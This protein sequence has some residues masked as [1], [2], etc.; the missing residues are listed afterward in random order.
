MIKI[1]NLIKF[2]FAKWIFLPPPKKKIIIYDTPSAKIIKNLLTDRYKTNIMIYHRRFEE[3]NI[4]IILLTFLN[5]NFKK[6]I[7][8]N[9]EFNYIKYVNPKLIITFVDNL[10]DFYELKKDFKSINFIS[11]QNGNRNRAFFVNSELADFKRV[12]LKNFKVDFFFVFNKAYKKAFKKYIDGNIVVSGSVKNNEVSFNNNLKNSKTE[13]N[14]LYISTF[15]EFRYN[16]LNVKNYYK[17][18]HKRYSYKDFLKAE[19]V[20]IPKIV[21]FCVSKKAKLTILAKT[22]SKKEHLF[23]KNIIKDPNLNWEFFPKPYIESGGLY[24]H[25][26]RMI[27]SS[28]AVIFI[29]SFLGYEAL[30]RNTPCAVF[31]IRKNFLDNLKCFNFGYPA[32]LQED[33]PFWTNVCSDKKVFKVLNAVFK[34]NKK[35]W[36]YLKKKYLSEVIYYNSKNTIIKKKI[37]E[38]LC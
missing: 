18:G 38:I 8:K 27:D 32:N 33:G 15:N 31:S 36:N 30:C 1:R 6:S 3:F 14:I 29:D 5:F 13:K 19:L 21:K 37:K 34:I 17:F 26:Y 2:F 12:K 4:F 7:L 25:N 23:Y 24:E 35:K 28:D 11:I 22:N 9:Y 16:Q 20:L 10:W